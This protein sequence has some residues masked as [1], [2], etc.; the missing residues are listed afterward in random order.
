MIKAEVRQASEG[1]DLAHWRDG[2]VLIA[3]A[4]TLYLLDAGGSVISEGSDSHANVCRTSCAYSRI[5]VIFRTIHGR[6]NSHLKREQWSVLRAVSRLACKMDPF[7]FF[8]TP[9]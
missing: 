4:P 9:F 8:D 7:S 1:G 3:C 5:S 6:V 2:Y